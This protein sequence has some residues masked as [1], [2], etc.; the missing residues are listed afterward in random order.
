[1]AHS[2]EAVKEAFVGYKGTLGDKGRTVGIVGVPLEEAMP[3]L[4]REFVMVPRR[5]QNIYKNTN[6]TIEVARSKDAFLSS[7]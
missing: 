5:F 2:L 6:L 1:L 3:M 4:Q 7:S